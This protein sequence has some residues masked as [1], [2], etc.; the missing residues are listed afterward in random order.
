MF[1][2]FYKEASIQASQTLAGTVDTYFF[3]AG[4]SVPKTKSAVSENE[5]ARTPCLL[6]KSI[7]FA[8]LSEFY[9]FSMSKGHRREK[10]QGSIFQQGRPNPS[11][12]STLSPMW[13]PRSGGSAGSNPH[14]GLGALGLAGIL[15]T[16]Q[17]GLL[18]LDLL[19]FSDQRREQA[20]IGMGDT[21]N[22]LSFKYV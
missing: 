6:G 20:R 5:K 1:C 10:D 14:I 19:T 7:S 12:I 8:T 13:R 15:L 18:L 21:Q 2:I 9:K 4:M 11:H 17:F 3:D 16:P 22:L